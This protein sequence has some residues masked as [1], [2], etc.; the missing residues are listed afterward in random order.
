MTRDTVFVDTS[1]WF[2]L[3]DKTDHYH[4]EA[5]SLYPKLLLKGYPRLTTTNLVIGPGL[6]L[7][8]ATSW[9]IP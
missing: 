2:S 1:A 4:Q 5:I 8:L 9:A 7:N 3:A 6:D